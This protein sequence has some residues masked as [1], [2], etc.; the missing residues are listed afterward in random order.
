MMTSLPNFNVLVPSNS[1]EVQELMM[2]ILDIC[3]TYLRLSRALE[4]KEVE[5]YN[6]KIGEIS[7][8]KTGKDV[9]LLTTGIMFSCAIDLAE[10][11]EG[12]YGISAAIYSCHSMKTF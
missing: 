4:R 9:A 11:L 5:K 7:E 12:Q 6:V 1:Y 10:E 3:P 2:R 8:V